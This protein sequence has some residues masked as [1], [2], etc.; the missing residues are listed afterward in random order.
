M[1]CE[2]Y[3]IKGR[4]QGVFFRAA[5]RDEA[6]RLGLT[7]FVRN[8]PNGDVEVIA[9]GNRDA[10]DELAA[11][12]WRGPPRARVSDVVSEAIVGHDTRGEFVVR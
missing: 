5:T 8:M 9:C 12:L 1:P 4:V 6:R 3:Q 10:L 11:W 7:G 2:R